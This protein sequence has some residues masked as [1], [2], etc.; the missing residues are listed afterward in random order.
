VNPESCLSERDGVADIRDEVHLVEMKCF[1]VVVHGQL[2]WRTATRGDAVA[3]AVFQPAGFYCHR[4]VVAMTQDAA[5][6]AAFR[7]VAANLDEQTG[8]LRSGSAELQM[9][10]DEMQIVPI[11][12]L[13]RPA[14]LGHTFYNRD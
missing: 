8:W 7:K 13:F 6:A 1:R 3:D 9:V 4:F 2:N 5:Q 10:V 14:N 11:Y 12:K